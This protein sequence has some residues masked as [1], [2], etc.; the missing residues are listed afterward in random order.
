M[1]G[2]AG[3]LSLGSAILLMALAALGSALVAAWLQRVILGRPI[4]AV[5]WAVTVIVTMAVG[6]A[7]MPGRRDRPPGG[8]ERK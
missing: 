4:L 3:R 1:A 5:T 6:W 2:S 8:P 7:A